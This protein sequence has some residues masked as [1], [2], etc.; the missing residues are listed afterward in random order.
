MAASQPSRWTVT[1]PERSCLRPGRSRR[2]ATAR[3]LGT[4]LPLAML[5][6]AGLGASAEAGLRIAVISDMN[7]AYGSTGYRPT[8][9]RAIAR[10]LEIRPDLVVSTGDMVAGQR[11]PHLSRSEVE[12]MWSAFHAEVSEPLAAAGI[13]LVVTPGNH[14]ASAYPGFAQ[15]RDIFE[16]QWSK[17]PPSVS[18]LDKTG[19]PFRYAFAANDVLFVSLDVTRIG[20][21]SAE[22]MD[23]LRDLLEAHGAAFKHRV[24]FSHLP[25]WPVAHGRE[26]EHIGD[27]EMQATLEDLGI[28]LYLSGHHHAFYP[29]AKGGVTFVAQ[30]CLGAGPRRL[31]GAASRAPRGFALVEFSDDTLHITALTGEDMATPLDWRT[32]PPRISSPVSDLVRADLAGTAL[33]GNPGWNGT[34]AA[35]AGGDR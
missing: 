31:L 6:L 22:A 15:E 9:N 26:T 20:P 23:W 12:R 8:V 14:D 7:G 13:P 11:R 35:Q 34:R 29:G 4:F 3:T 2:S 28:D 10:I 24:V 32:L 30:A 17:R 5:L 21:L 19:Y 18:F 25:L 27:P 33:P 1:D 16:Q